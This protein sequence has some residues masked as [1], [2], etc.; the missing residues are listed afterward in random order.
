M[1]RLDFRFSASAEQEII[2]ILERTGEQFGTAA[3]RRYQSLIAQAVR[4][5]AENPSRIGARTDGARTHYHLRHSRKRV[6]GE[7]VAEP[8][9]YL[10]V[11]IDGSLMTILAIVH[12]GMVAGIARR[13]AEGEE[14]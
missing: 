12:D 7:R 6:A 3:S 14:T 1:S 8:R 9:H 5:L 13:I 10:V 4:D 2:Q 11:R